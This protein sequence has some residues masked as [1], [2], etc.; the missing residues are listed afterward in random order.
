MLKLG[1]SR[2]VC[3]MPANSIKYARRFRTFI[4]RNY[5][6]PNCKIWEAARAT[7]AAPTFFKSIAIGEPGQIKEQFLDA[8]VGCNNPTQEVLDESRLVFGD[9]RPLGVLISL[10][11][12][13]KPNPSLASSTGFQKI[14]PTKLNE[15]ANLMKVLAKIATDSEKVADD[16]SRRF[17]N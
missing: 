6:T 11:T 12:G 7:T 2:F 13:Q 14:L 15:F 5:A 17:E 3:A 8:A 9:D 16:M 4:V 10:G 1:P